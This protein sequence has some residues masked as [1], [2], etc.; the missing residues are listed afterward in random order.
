MSKGNIGQPAPSHSNGDSMTTLTGTVFYGDHWGKPRPHQ[1]PQGANGECV[2][3]T[4]ADTEKLAKYKAEEA[5]R[6]KT[7]V[8]NKYA[9]GKPKFG[10][11]Y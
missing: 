7:Y 4:P 3:K 9:S 2:T 10:R 8:S 11:R 5:E 1:E 6:M